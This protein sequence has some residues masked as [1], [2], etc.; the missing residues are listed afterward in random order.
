MA[1]VTLKFEINPNADSEK[2]KSIEN[3]VG[4]LSNTS[5]KTNTNNIFQINYDNPPTYSF[6]GLN[7]LSMAKGYFIFSPNGYLANT[8]GSIGVLTSEQNPVEFVWGT[9]PENKEYSVKLTINSDTANLKDIVFYGDK[10]AN[11]FPIEAKI[12]GEI[13]FIRNDDSQWVI[14]FKEESSSHTIEFTKWNRAN[15]NAVLVLIRV[16]LKYYE[17]DQ[18]NGLQSIEI[19][20]QSNT[21][22]KEIMYGVVPNNGSAKITDIDGEL[23]DLIE[24]EIIPSSNTPVCFEENGKIK[25]YHITTDN[26]YTPDKIFSVEMSNSLSQWEQ[27]Q[28]L[29]RAYTGGTSL[30][31]ILEG[32]LTKTLNVSSADVGRMCNKPINI[33]DTKDEI[34]VATF[35]SN[36]YIDY[37]YLEPDNLRATVDKICT[38]AQL[39]CYE[40]EDA[41]YPQNIVFDTARPRRLKGVYSKPVLL[42]PPYLQMQQPQK[43]IILRNKYDKVEVQYTKVKDEINYSTIIHTYQETFTENID[44]STETKG[45]ITSTTGNIP[46][47][48]F[49]GIINY[50]KKFIITFENKSNFN[51]EEIITRATGVDGKGTPNISYSVKYDYYKGGTASFTGSAND[52]LNDDFSIKGAISRDYSN[53]EI[54]S[55]ESTLNIKSYTFTTAVG[56]YTNSAIATLDNH[57][58]NTT[59]KYNGNTIELNLL[60]EQEFI[61]MNN[62]PNDTA[63]G[64][65]T[66]SKSGYSPKSYCEKY[67]PREINIS[68]YGDKRT[69][70]FNDTT[71][72]SKGD[73]NKTVV[74]INANTLLQNKTIAG[75]IA[76]NILIDYANGISTATIKCFNS[77]I[78]D[79]SN[80]IRRVW[81]EGG[82]FEIGDLVRIDKDNDNDFFESP[83]YKHKDGSPILFK[84]KG[85]SHNYN[86]SPNCVL[87]LQE[88]TN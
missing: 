3:T 32:V 47:R 65:G 50:Y 26:D 24:S 33:G 81:S 74:K 16:T 71:I 57:S 77:D 20:N 37:D 56:S 73:G 41:E 64:W 48:C 4:S 63:N 25:S 84:V 46:V 30:Y 36:I 17:I 80:N 42:I 9:V 75:D 88:I 35:L 2:I 69:I 23:A 61:G 10:K 78:Y 67:V 68:F 5:F 43:D 28:F 40:T 8:D 18:F 39:N 27:I 19:K 6:G 34:S 38:V 82:T 15:Y 52:L 72:L 58:D 53:A 44:F 11:Q 12:D 7:A 87:E 13:T 45:T 1:S 70:S 83:Q 22:M 79:S 31:R 85:V 59:A 14:D 21:A 55:G 86:G 66:S 49:A 76:D 60:V 54:T 51:L 29:G 62:N